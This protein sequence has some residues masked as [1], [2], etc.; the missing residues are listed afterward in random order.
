[1]LMQATSQASFFAIGRCLLDDYQEVEHPELYIRNT[2]LNIL[3]TSK[4]FYNGK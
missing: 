4:F 2:Y 3:I 1:M